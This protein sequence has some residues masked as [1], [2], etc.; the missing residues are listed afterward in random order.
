VTCSEAEIKL[1]VKAGVVF[2]HLCC[3]PFVCGGRALVAF[4][5]S[6][7]PHELHLSEKPA[8]LASQDERR[9]GLT[10]GGVTRCMLQRKL[11]VATVFDGLN[12]ERLLRKR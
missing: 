12:L 5:L 11:S 8:H 10:F 4:S 2:G 7:L 1:E 3:A 6:L 9:G